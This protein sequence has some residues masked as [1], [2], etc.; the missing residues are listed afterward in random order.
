[1]ILS[2]ILY[3]YSRS[4]ASS[5]AKVQTLRGGSGDGVPRLS[6]S[7][8]SR[9]KARHYGVKFVESDTDERYAWSTGASSDSQSYGLS[10]TALRNTKMRVRLKCSH[11][12]FACGLSGVVRVLSVPKVEHSLAKTAASNCV[13]SCCGIPYRSN[14]SLYTAHATVEPD[15]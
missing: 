10:C 11:F 4:S 6:W 13:P 8:I 7:C 15:W 5:F 12:I 2:A 9:L 1:M 14:N 3:D